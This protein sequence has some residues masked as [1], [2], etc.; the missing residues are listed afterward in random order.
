[1]IT[2]MNRSKNGNKTTNKHNDDTLKTIFTLISPPNLQCGVTDGG[3]VAAGDVA[4]KPKTKHAHTAHTALTALTAL[5]TQSTK[6][7][8]QST[9]IFKHHSHNPHNLHHRTHTH[10]ALLPVPGSG[11]WCPLWPRLLLPH[12]RHL[13]LEFYYKTYKIVRCACY[14]CY[15]GYEAAEQAHIWPRRVRNY[16]SLDRK[17]K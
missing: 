11:P 4:H 14:P 6:L 5:H 17:N 2:R 16:L 8:T 10:T 7:H 9:H 3:Q 15:V 1:M 13:T 12:W